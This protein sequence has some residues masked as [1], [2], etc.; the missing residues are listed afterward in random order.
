M[1]T[2]EIAAGLFAIGGVAVGAALTWFGDWIGWSRSRREADLDRQRDALLELLRHSAIA[3]GHAGTIAGMLDAKQSGRASKLT[4]DTTA[5]DN[6][7]AHASVAVDALRVLAP[8]DVVKPA[9]DMLISLIDAREASLRLG[10]GTDDLQN[11]MH[12]VY[13]CKLK[14]LEAASRHDLAT[15]HSAIDEQIEDARLTLVRR[16]HIRQD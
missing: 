6:A 8:A 15:K 3:V 16:G 5:L 4:L 1:P 13:A 2:V 14:L 9:V 10:A 11:D 7:V 12:S